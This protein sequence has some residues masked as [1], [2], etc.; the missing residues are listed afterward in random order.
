MAGI[1]WTPWSKPSV[2]KTYKYKGYTIE[3]WVQ[4]SS[5]PY[6][7]VYHH[8]FVGFKDGKR[9]TSKKNQHDKYSDCVREIKNIIE[10]NKKGFYFAGEEVSWEEIPLSVRKH[11][12]PY[13]FDEKGNDC[14]P[15][16]MDERLK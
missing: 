16:V 5:S 11:D 7:V 10:R 8:E 15:I 9:V 1:K 14:F 2:L 13:Y 4:S 3:Y 6:S 12:Y